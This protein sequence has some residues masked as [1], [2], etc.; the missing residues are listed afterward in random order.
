MSR[1]PDP[2]R[3]YTAS[4]TGTLNRLVG[5]GELPER[6]EAWLAVWEGQAASE[7]IDRFRDGFWHD[8]WRWIDD[9]RARRMQG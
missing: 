3:L 4:R 1:R 9:L 6:A 5:D 2:D 7:G 8:G